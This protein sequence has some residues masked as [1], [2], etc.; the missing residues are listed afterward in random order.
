V[1]LVRMHALC[2][3]LNATSRSLLNACVH[4]REKYNSVNVETVGELQRL[5][6]EVL[7]LAF[8]TVLQ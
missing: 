7:R 1:L 3:E 8:S 4:D 6:V 5:K 2:S